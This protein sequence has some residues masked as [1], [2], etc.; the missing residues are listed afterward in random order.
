MA[1]GVS[2]FIF[3]SPYIIGS[4]K[5]IELPVFFASFALLASG[6][7]C[8][9]ASASAQQVN[10][11]SYSIDFDGASITVGNYPSL[12]C[13]T[14]EMNEVEANGKLIAP[15]KYEYND[16]YYS[17]VDPCRPYSG[18]IELPGNIVAS[19]IWNIKCW[20][21]WEPLTWH[22]VKEVGDVSYFLCKSVVDT[23]RW[24]GGSYDPANDWENSEMRQFLNGEFYLTAFSDE[25]RDAVVPFTSSENTSKKAIQDN[26]SLITKSELAEH[27]SFQ[28][29]AASG[30]AIAKSLYCL[31][32]ES[33]RCVYYLNSTN[34]TVEP[35]KVDI[36]E[37]SNLGGS[38]TVNETGVDTQIGVRPL[39]AVRSSALIRKASG[40]GGG[41]GRGAGANVPLILGI[42][43]SVLGAGGL[44]AFFM[45][46][47]K[48]KLIKVDKT[49]APIWVFASVS[50]GLLISI[51]G[52]SMVFAGTL[53][54]GGFGA[55]S[56]IGYWSTPEFTLDASSSTFGY[57]YYMGIA[58]NGDVY[59]Y[60]GDVWGSDSIHNYLLNPYDGVGSWEI[61]GNKLIIHASP[62][63]PSFQWEEIDTTYTPTNGR[64]FGKDIMIMNE[65]SAK[66]ESYVVSGYRWSHTS[67][68]E[69]TG[70]PI[71]SRDAGIKA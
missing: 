43:F 23:H 26:V 15:N 10:A 28:R 66:T 60:Y 3:R 20:F 61:K 57:R 52:I 41:G 63:W 59:R 17:P 11:E 12:I 14:A 50:C 71:M 44:A 49:K 1:R 58:S 47:K 27:S 38:H 13:Y 33:A 16:N 32:N 53:G 30:Y 5:R 54:G 69:P 21:K 46:W 68:I 9:R 29:P 40:G 34:N 70:K 48:G 64:G 42:I 35:G 22:F 7:G 65:G 18:G 24:Q 67:T 51:I 37:K 2:A 36:A 45:L 8:F 6:L 31:T 25:E 55:S 56:P 4:M 19:Q 39:I 62:S